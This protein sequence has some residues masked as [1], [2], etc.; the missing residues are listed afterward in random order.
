MTSDNGLK[1]THKKMPKLTTYDDLRNIRRY[2]VFYRG[3]RLY[4]ERFRDDLKHNHVVIMYCLRHHNRVGKLMSKAR[5]V[6]WVKLMD[7]DKSESRNNIFISTLIR[8]GYIEQQ[9]KYFF[10]TPAGNTALQ[11]LERTVKQQRIDR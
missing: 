3:L 11:D 4:N 1:I 2:L 6:E 8:K 9:G 5:L 7:F 10:I